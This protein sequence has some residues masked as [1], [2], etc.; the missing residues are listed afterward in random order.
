MMSL[1]ARMR[2]IGGPL[3]VGLVAF[4]FVFLAIDRPLADDFSVG[5][6]TISP[7]WSRA[8]PPGAKVAGGYMMIT[9]ASGEADRLVSATADIAA[10][11]EIHEMAVVDGVMKMRPLDDGVEVPAGGMVE[12]KPGSYHIMLMGL[13]GALKEGEVFGGTLTFEKAGSVDVTYQIGAMGSD[14]AP[15][16][17]HH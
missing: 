13:T 10:R 16:H 9:N 15:D 4:A 14:M 12:L 2:M 8:T 6:L 7:P 3:S 17:H 11:V 5:S 1:F